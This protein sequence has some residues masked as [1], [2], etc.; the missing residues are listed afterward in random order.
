LNQAEPITPWKSRH[1]DSR[2]PGVTDAEIDPERG[3][4]RMKMF[5]FQSGEARCEE[6]R[7][8]ATR[9]WAFDGSAAGSRC[10]WILALL[11]IAL[12][13]TSQLALGQTSDRFNQCLNNCFSVCDTGPANLAWGCREDCGRQCGNLNQNSP[14]PYGAIAFGTRGAEGISWNKGSGAAADQGA[15]ATCSRYG[16]NCRVVYRFQNTC[17]ALA[18]AKGAQHFEAATGNTKEKAEANATAACQQRWGTCLSDLSAC[19]LAST[20]GLN[21]PNPPAQPHATSWGAIAYSAPDMQAGW[22]YSKNDRSLAEKEA[23]TACSQR[24]RACVLRTVFNKQCAALASDRGF[25]GWATSTD[26]R[27]AQQ[28]AVE[29]C[30]K[31]GGTR[32]TL[33]VFFCSF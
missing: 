9:V 25:A 33:H 3:F 26:P 32:C 16:S 12:G 24:G 18:L 21:K 7:P 31:N 5:H 1:A 27:E 6:Q 19:S 8:V 28:K 15:I 30:T 4:E 17:A 14:A 22:S 10:R 11:G 29:A 20:S 2:K 23:M 13:V